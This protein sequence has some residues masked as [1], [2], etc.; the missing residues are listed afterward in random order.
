MRKPKKDRRMRTSTL[1]FIVAAAVTGIFILTFSFSYAWGRSEQQIE[2]RTVTDVFTTIDLEDFEGNSFT[3]DDIADTKLIAYNIW[4]T[5]CPACLGE[6]GAL[7][8]LSRE[9]DPSQ[10]RLIGICADLHG[11]DGELKPQQLETA[12]E[13]MKAAGVTFP[14]LIPDQG[15]RDFFRS[16]IVG[17]PTT[18]FVN[19]EGKIIKATAGARC[20]EQWE[21]L[22]DAELENL[23]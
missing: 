16:T 11:A 23:Q 13:L 20:L 7:E 1:K 15:L 2:E 3:M 8:E 9:Y 21:K 18:F 10:F 22:V 6:M 12:K 5:T 17:F 14:N 19:N 4:E